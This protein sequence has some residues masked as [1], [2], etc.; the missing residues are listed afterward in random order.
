MVH[1]NP[2]TVYP[3]EQQSPEFFRDTFVKENTYINSLETPIDTIIEG[4]RGSGKSSLFNYLEFKHQLCYYNNDL[5]KYL[6]DRQKNKYIGIL[7]HVNDDLLNTTKF[8]LLL[9]N[10]LENNVFIDQLC[11]SDLIS[12]ILY[13]I[14]H[15]FLE[16]KE[17]V[18]YCDNL[19]KESF[20]DF[21]QRNVKNLDRKKIYKKYDLNASLDNSALLKCLEEIFKNERDLISIFAN[22]KFQM[23][24]VSYSGNLPELNY[25]YDFL[26]DF[27]N[28][29]QISEF[30]FYFLIDNAED[31]SKRMQLCIDELIYHRKHDK[32][33]IKLAIRK[34]ATWNYNKIQWPHD[35]I[36]IDV[37]ELYSTKHSVYF[38]RIKEISKKRLELEEY[39][40]Q[41][42]DFFPE[43][44]PEKELLDSIKTELKKY[45]EEE[46]EKLSRSAKGTPLSKKE[47]VL[48]RVNRYAQAE[49]FRR[50][51][52]TPKSY[53]GFENIVHLSSGVIRQFLDLASN[54]YIEEKK[55]NTK[56][57]FSH[58]SLNAQNDV[59]KKYADDFI[60]GLERQYKELEHQGDLIAANKQKKLY[61]LIEALGDYY[62]SRLMDPELVEPR[63]FTFSLKDP[64]TDT[65][66]DEVLKIGVDMNYFQSYWYSSKIGAGKYKGYAFNRRLCPRYR[67]DHTSFR[68]RIELTTA[69]L[70]SAM[71][72]RSLKRSYNKLLPSQTTLD[73]L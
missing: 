62:K 24:K 30:S 51:K 14:L 72:T 8:D 66:V 17:M 36:K 20:F 4:W 68:G 60:D 55:Q 57:D 44:L 70:K 67:I 45:Y 12:T 34:G 1:E 53:A 32:F 61:Y 19:K 2:F 13:R 25:L 26:S 43:S 56:L 5:D 38:E 27:K 69:E 41:P 63:V 35:Y 29:F 48:N 31:S 16:C 47:F 18:A 65:E 71:E 21:F 73:P 37:D 54:M 23:K 46:Y 59:I 52:K 6:K 7:I 10:N 28:I 33:A 3:P 22:G 50:L 58:I 64:D 15:T 42:S 39:F 40:V 11:M 49:L 9:E